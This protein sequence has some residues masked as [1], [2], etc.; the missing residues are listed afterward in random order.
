LGRYTDLGFSYTVQEQWSD[1]P[2]AGSINEGRSYWRQYFGMSL[3][4]H[5][6]E[7]A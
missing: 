3:T 5:P 6:R 7:L 4:W 2:S 1:A